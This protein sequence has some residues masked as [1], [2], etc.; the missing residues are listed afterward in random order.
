MQRAERIARIVDSIVSTAFISSRMHALMSMR[1]HAVGTRV[2]ASPFRPPARVPAPY[3]AFIS[4]RIVLWNTMRLPISVRYCLNSATRRAP[5]EEGPREGA[6]GRRASTVRWYDRTPSS[7]GVLC[8]CARVCRVALRERANSRKESIRR[9]PRR[10]LRTARRQTR[11]GNATHL[12]PH[13]MHERAGERTQRQMPSTN[14]S[15]RM[16]V[17]EWWTCA[18]RRSNEEVCSPPLVSCLIHPASE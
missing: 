17:K 3:A 16:S 6:L 13:T 5:N 18:V 4:G 1:A 14:S 7:E 8:V 11:P 2:V 9:R 12:T 15:S 10:T